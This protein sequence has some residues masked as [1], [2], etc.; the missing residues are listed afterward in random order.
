MVHW[1]THCCLSH[2][3]LL[4]SLVNID[5]HEHSPAITLHVTVHATVHVTVHVK[6]CITVHVTLHTTVHVTVHATVHVIVHVVLACCSLKPLECN[7]S[8]DMKNIIWF[9]CS[10]LNCSWL[11][12]HD[13]LFQQN[14]QFEIKSLSIK[15]RITNQLHSLHTSTSILLLYDA[16]WHFTTTGMSN[17]KKKLLQHGC[18]IS[19]QST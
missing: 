17:Y 6:V 4:Q 11:D 7:K 9:S 14:I 2:R 5:T 1:N 15:H 3:K 16:I 13:L 10:Y 18:I 8:N 19:K 12:N